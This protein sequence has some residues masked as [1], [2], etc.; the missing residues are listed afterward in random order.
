MLAGAFAGQMFIVST[1]PV[2]PLKGFQ[3]PLPWL[4]LKLKDY[5]SFLSSISYRL[6]AQLMREQQGL[7]YLAYRQNKDTQ[8][9]A[10][11]DIL[12]NDTP[13]ETASGKVYTGLLAMMA[14]RMKFLHQNFG[15]DLMIGEE[16]FSEPKEDVVGQFRQLLMKYRSTQNF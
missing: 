12:F 5:D 16:Y 6:G 8:K 14:H 3:Q 7:I 10:L 9:K 1:F 13:F 4:G 15:Y 2:Y 11:D